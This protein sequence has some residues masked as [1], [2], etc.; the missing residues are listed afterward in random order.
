MSKAHVFDICGQTMCQLTIRYVS[1]VCGST[2]HAPFGNVSPGAKMHLI[3][4]N[5]RACLLPLQALLNPV[6]ILP[7]MLMYFCHDTGCQRTQFRGKT[8]GISFLDSI[9]IVT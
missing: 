7:L 9:V 4:G 5:R 6:I 3:D 8:V 2:L 1:N